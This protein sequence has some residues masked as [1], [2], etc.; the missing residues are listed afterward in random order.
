MEPTLFLILLN[1]VEEINIYMEIRV[2]DDEYP[3]KEVRFNKFE[4]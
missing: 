1:R 2:G 4:E 3:P